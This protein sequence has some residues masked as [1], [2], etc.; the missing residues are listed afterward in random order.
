MFT[1]GVRTRLTGTAILLLVLM[2]AYLWR[3]H[4]QAAI[5]TAPNESVRKTESPPDPVFEKRRIGQLLLTLKPG[6]TRTDVET[7]LG[8]P[9]RLIEGSFENKPILSAEY[10]CSPPNLPP[11]GPDD[12]GYL[13]HVVYDASGPVPVFQEIYGPSGTSGD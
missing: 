5:S 13:M 10:C 3:S 11:I 2:V 6:M 9:L 7:V 8:P 4:S 12:L 1:P